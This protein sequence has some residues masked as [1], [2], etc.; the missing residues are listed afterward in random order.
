[1]RVAASLRSAW[2]SFAMPATSVGAE[3]GSVARV[4]PTPAL[5]VGHP[6]AHNER[7]RVK[8]MQPRQQQETRHQRPEGNTLPDSPATPVPDS[9]GES[10]FQ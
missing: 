9:S 8:D 7:L 3:R 6:R 5:R 10:R 4:E 2:L 1:M